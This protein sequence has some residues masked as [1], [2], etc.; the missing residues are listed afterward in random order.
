MT[1]VGVIERPEN[2]EPK[3]SRQGS[4]LRSVD[5]I[6]WHNWGKHNAKSQGGIMK[7]RTSKNGD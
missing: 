1:E 5:E 2:Q 7:A 4:D 3:K 6:R